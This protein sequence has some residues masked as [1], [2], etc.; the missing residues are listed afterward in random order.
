VQGE[1]DVNLCHRA[2]LHLFIRQ[3][4]DP[5][6]HDQEVEAAGITLGTSVV[7]MEVREVERMMRERMRNTTLYLRRDWH[8][9]L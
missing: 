9:N 2:R 8:A 3:D 5:H 7:K 1:R 4:A 6:F